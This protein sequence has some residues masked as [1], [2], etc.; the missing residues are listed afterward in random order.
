MLTWRALNVKLDFQVAFYK[1]AEKKG[2]ETNVS[3]FKN[4]H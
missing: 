1:L 2:E 4:Y 3:K